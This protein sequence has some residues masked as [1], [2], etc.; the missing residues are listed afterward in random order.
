MPRQLR[1]RIGVN[2]P[3]TSSVTLRTQLS[4]PLMTS[5]TTFTSLPTSLTPPKARDECSSLI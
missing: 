3:S 5:R 4:S 1:R 2:K